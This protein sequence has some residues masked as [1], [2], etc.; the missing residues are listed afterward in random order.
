VPNPDVAETIQWWEDLMT[1]L[2]RVIMNE[3]CNSPIL[4][5][6]TVSRPDQ[7]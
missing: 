3:I 1:A 5:Q 4:N 7:D 2:T 6:F